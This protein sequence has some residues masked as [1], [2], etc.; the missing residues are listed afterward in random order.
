MGAFPIH[1]ALSIVSRIYCIPKSY[2]LNEWMDKCPPLDNK[3]D[4]MS[5]DHNSQ[6]PQHRVLPKTVVELGL[7]SRNQ[8]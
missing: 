5:T 2:L 8:V 4:T 7:S 1:L 6:S 3:I